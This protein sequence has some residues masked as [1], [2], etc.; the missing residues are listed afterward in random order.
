MK[1]DCSTE[2]KTEISYR[3]DRSKNPRTQDVHAFSYMCHL[4]SHIAVLSRKIITLSHPPTHPRPSPLLQPLHTIPTV[5]MYSR[6]AVYALDDGSVIAYNP[7][8]PTEET[9]REI[10]DE[11]GSPGEMEDFDSS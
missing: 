6:M 7:I 3:Y 8:A 2:R 4:L 1:C 5:R 9:L 10:V 11:F